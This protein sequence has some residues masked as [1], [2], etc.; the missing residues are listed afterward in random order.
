MNIGIPVIQG[1]KYEVTL[2]AG[3][4]QQ[5]E[6][7]MWICGNFEISS[8]ILREY[9]CCRFVKIFCMTRN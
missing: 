4:E 1:V 2:F 3:M 5:C 7:L 8:I 6:L 9:A